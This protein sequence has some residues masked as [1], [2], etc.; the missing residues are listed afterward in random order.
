MT[1]EL[2]ILQWIIEGVLG[3]SP[4]GTVVKVPPREPIRDML[5]GIAVNELA[6]TLTSSAERDALR[7][8][9]L[10]LIAETAKREMER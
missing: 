1:D 10:Q 7:Q 9:S 4:Q 6:E 8:A 2:G 5:I 3:I